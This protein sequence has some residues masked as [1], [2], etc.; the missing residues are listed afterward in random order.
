MRPPARRG[1]RDERQVEAA[2]RWSEIRL[3][4]D[5]GAL[6]VQEP[7]VRLVGDREVDAQVTGKLPRSAR[8]IDELEAEASPVAASRRWPV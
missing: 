6:R 7:V 1:V 2:G 4:P 3:W 8:K 5:L